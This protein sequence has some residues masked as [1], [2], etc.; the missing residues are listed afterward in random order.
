MRPVR[1]HLDTSDYAALYRA[2]AGTPEF[3]VRDELIKMKDNGRIEIG[4]S[5]HVV[6][7]LLQEATPEFRDDRLARAR[8]LTQLC[9]QNAFPYPSDLGTDSRFS[10]A[11]LWVPR[12]DLEEIEIECL[13]RWAMETIASSPGL[14]R[15][16]RRAFSKRSYFVE[17][18]RANP[19]NFMRIMD[20]R[21]PLPFGKEFVERGDFQH[22]IL[23]ELARDEANKALYFHITDPVTVYETWFEKYKWTN[24]I[25]ERRDK[26]AD[27]MEEMLKALKAMLDGQKSLKT[28][29]EDAINATGENALSPDGREALK[30]LKKDVQVFRTEIT[31]PDELSKHPAWIK[32]VGEDGALLAS[33]I[34]HAFYREKREF[35]RSDAIDMI[36][37]MYL[38]HTDLWRGDKD[39]SNLLIKNRVSFHERVVPSLAELLDRIEVQVTAKANKTA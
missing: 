11:G 16:E 5:Y 18:V 30:K 38:P 6:F 32:I 31:S 23:G 10:K 36:H 9:G 22:Y 24:P 13:V 4:L 25:P 28:E 19:S 3:R 27:K 29:I 14:S 34:F 2:K 21:W 15:R 17:W 33:Q 39:F 35:R 12:I 1:L 8:L 20:A 26:M 7:E 37:A